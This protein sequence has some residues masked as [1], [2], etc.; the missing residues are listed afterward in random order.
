MAMDESN[1]PPVSDSTAGSVSLP[2]TAISK[3]PEHMT[4][5]TSNAPR[6]ANRATAA[7]GA[8]LAG[9]LLL[10][11]LTALAVL[12]LVG[13][14]LDRTG[15]ALWTMRALGPTSFS[16]AFLSG[17]LVAAAIPIGLVIRRRTRRRAGKDARVWWWV[18]SAGLVAT[19]LAFGFP[20]DLAQ[21]LPR[22]LA[23]SVAIVAAIW[24]AV[25]LT[26]V[27]VS[28]AVRL[29]VFA[30]NRATGSG[31][32]R[33]ALLG[34]GLIQL[35]HAPFWH[36]TARTDS[37]DVMT[38]DFEER[39]EVLQPYADSSLVG[40]LRIV[41]IAMSDSPL[42]TWVS[43]PRPEYAS[44]GR[45][46]LSALSKE[47]REALDST[48]SERIH[49]CLEQLMVGEEGASPVQAAIVALVRNYNMGNWAAEDV[50]M[51]A[52]VAV[53]ISHGNDP[54]EDTIRYFY[55]SCKNGAAMLGRHQRSQARWAG[56]LY[57]SCPVPRPDADVDACVVRRALELLDPRDREIL[58][59][60]YLEEYEYK[61]IAGVIDIKP[62]N[63]RKRVELALRRLRQSLGETRN[64]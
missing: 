34:A 36:D 18:H 32:L 53:C 14:T 47:D 1:D 25:G 23:G 22:A 43:Q 56:A 19:V 39:L 35:L 37:I 17:L 4:A 58:E 12:A 57:E 50:V 28:S 24:L 40:E 33:G 52:A 59:L 46:V 2:A 44:L 38:L 27:L 21:A 16:T 62:A 54:K 10:L 48:P 61:A 8:L 30:Y 64:H 51:D 63:A 7:L 26:L 60:R 41:L 11:P 6:Q 20:A 29:C 13:V 31:A 15:W 3:P 55:T 5:G 9:C 49:G 45:L 42:S